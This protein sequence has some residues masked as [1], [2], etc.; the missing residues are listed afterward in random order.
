[1]SLRRRLGRGVRRAVGPLCLAIGLA[2]EPADAEAPAA[3]DHLLGDIGGLRPFLAQYGAS[4]ELTETSELLGNLTGGMRQGAIYE[5][6]TEM[7]LTL[8]LRPRFGWPGV[9][10]A[11]ALQIHGRGLA[12][13]NI[14]NLD[15]VSNIEARATTRLRELWYE[16]DIGDWLHLRIGEQSADREFLVSSTA[17][18]LVNGT[19]GWPTLPATD[20][21]A[22]GPAY[23]LGTPA[24]RLRLDAG[25]ALAWYTGAFNGNPAGGGL[26][27]PQRRDPSGTAFRTN[28]G[29]LALT[30]LR[31]NPGSSPDN[32]TYRLGGWYNSE[33]FR[34][35]HLPLSHSGDFSLYGVVDQPLVSSEGGG[36][37]SAFVRAMGAPGDRNL[38]DLYLDGGLA[39]KGPFGRKDDT[40]ALGFAYARIGSAARA[41][42][43]EMGAPVRSS[44]RL[45]ELTY[46]AQLTPWWQL[47][48]DLQYIV[49]PGGGV[50]NPLQPESR[51]GDALV[52]GLRTQITF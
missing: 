38:V 18:V 36:Q 52:L 50:L 11:D 6:L 25:G 28:D 24:V 3:D 21:P 8:D 23:P 33:P 48:P 12:A 46:Q 47:Q 41:R 4:V 34:D 13:N 31:Y 20:L 17:Q 5:G 35:Q 2:P 26:G 37:L 15:T 45:V 9:I 29:V 10:R 22:G 39:Y 16:Q 49:N 43:A 40:V 19:F 30:E 14:G 42:D 27:D 32:G 1:M 51:I 7:S 44:E